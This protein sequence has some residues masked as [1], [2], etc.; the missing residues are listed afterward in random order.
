MDI[1]YSKYEGDKKMRCP[2]CKKEIGDVISFCPECGQKLEQSAQSSKT[3]QYWNE[4]NKAD[5]QRNEQYRDLVNRT[6]KEKR[7]RNNK[8]IAIF[9][10]IVAII[11]ITVFGGM[12]YNEYSRRM[13][14]EVQVQLVGKTLTAHSTHMEGLGWIIHEYNQ[15]TFKDESSLDY[16][17]ISTTGPREEDE[18]PQY[19]GTYSYTVSR[20]ITGSYKITT[21]GNVYELKVNDNNEVQGIS[22]K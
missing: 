2:F 22:Q 17:F 6:T 1:N 9:G 10:F 21:D 20:T 12:K 11:V 13:I 16:A 18:L 7:I 5:S 15:L 8:S 4:V 3:E 19:R 14:T